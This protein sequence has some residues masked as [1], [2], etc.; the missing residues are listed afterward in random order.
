MITYLYYNQTLLGRLVTDE[1]VAEMTG[2]EMLE[3]P[4]ACGASG[5]L[6]QRPDGSY[7][8]ED[9]S[10]VEERRESKRTKADWLRLKAE[11]VDGITSGSIELHQL[12]DD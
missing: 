1:E 12:M 9:A 2:G 6:F 5:V 4:T 3:A 11:E 7:G 10:A 8:V